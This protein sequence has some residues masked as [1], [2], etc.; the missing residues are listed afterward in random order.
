[1]RRDP[2]GVETS[3][4]GKRW[5]VFTTGQD[6]RTRTQFLEGSMTPKPIVREIRI[7]N[8][9]IFLDP[10]IEYARQTWLQQ[11]QYTID[12]VNAVPYHYIILSYSHDCPF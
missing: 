2:K 9:V 10:P 8:Q 4:A 11:L 3:S 5:A 6:W 12:L 7:Q 1:M